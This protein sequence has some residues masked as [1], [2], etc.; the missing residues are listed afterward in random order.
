MFV[1]TRRWVE[2]VWCCK[3]LHGSRCILW[4]K[5]LKRSV[6]QK[7]SWAGPEGVSWNP[8][9]QAKQSQCC[10]GQKS[11]WTRGWWLCDTLKDGTLNWW[12]KIKTMLVGNGIV[13]AWW[14]KQDLAVCWEQLV[15]QVKHLGSPRVSG[16]EVIAVGQVGARESVMDRR[17]ALEA[18]LKLSGRS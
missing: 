4:P 2:Y 18:K 5:C 11:L 16:G 1:I 10:W 12:E 17:Q 7:D 3:H 8:L 6:R 13:R 9:P 14:C 15:H